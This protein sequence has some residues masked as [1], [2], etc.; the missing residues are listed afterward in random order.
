MASIKPLSDS[1][2]ADM[3]SRNHYS[4][5]Y[6]EHVCNRYLNFMNS[7]LTPS[8]FDEIIYCL[9]N[10]H[11]LP[12]GISTHTANFTN[13][14]IYSENS[15]RPITKQDFPEELFKTDINFIFTEN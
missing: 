13:A 10:Q 5:I 1:A 3:L 9:M 4:K 11:K 6:Y 12:L 2:I 7:R 14:R 15:E 8:Q